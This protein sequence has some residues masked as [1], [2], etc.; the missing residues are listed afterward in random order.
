MKTFEEI[1]KLAHEIA[2]TYCDGRWV[3]LGGGGY[4]MWRVVPR[5]WGQVW[6]IA[7]S[8]KPMTGN[9][10][11]TWLDQWQEKSPVTLPSHWHDEEGIYR[12]IPRK[13]EIT[14]KNKLSLNKSIQFITNQQKY[15]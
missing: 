5:A 12:E 1:P 9:L 8:S 3:A 6:N 10:P 14:E 2:H 15:M 11:Q 4:D 13:P 7:S